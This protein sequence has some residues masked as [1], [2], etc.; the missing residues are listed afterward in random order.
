MAPSNAMMAL[1]HPADII[2]DPKQMPKKRFTHILLHDSFRVGITIKGVDG[3]LEALGGVLLWFKVN[4][5]NSWLQALCQHELARDKHDIIFSHISAASQKLASGSPMFASLYL[6]S[7]GLVKVVLVVC[8]WANKLWAYPLTIFVF[9]AFM[10][11]QTYRFTHTH[12]WALVILTLFDG[13]LI[14]L[15][16][17]EYQDQKALKSKDEKH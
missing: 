16:W 11:Y 2:K 6:L 3:L 9:A 4:T 14:F 1:A 7:H 10:V 5:L 8:L 15:T 13:L 12:S 17:K